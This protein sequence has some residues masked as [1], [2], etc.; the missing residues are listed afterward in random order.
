MWLLCGSACVM[1]AGLNLISHMHKACGH[2][3]SEKF[4]YILKYHAMAR[5]NTPYYT[6]TPK[7]LHAELRIDI[8]AERESDTHRYNSRKT[9][10]KSYP[11]LSRAR[12]PGKAK[13]NHTPVPSG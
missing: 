2:Q 4:I 8:H 11:R 9:E 12:A 7:L 13:E 5:T 3:A 1:L 6:H 10:T